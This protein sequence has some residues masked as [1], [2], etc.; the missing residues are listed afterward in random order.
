MSIL[1]DIEIEGLCDASK[2]D[3]SMITPFIDHSRRVRDDDP[4][5]SAIT[6][7]LSSYGYD[8][9]LGNEFLIFSNS[10]VN[11]VPFVDPKNFNPDICV[12]HFSDEFVII[13][14]HGFMLGK[15]VE[16][17]RMPENVTCLI[18]G[19]STYARSGITTLAT[20]LEAGWHGQVTLEFYNATP[21]PVKMYANEGCVQAQFFRGSPCRV[22][23]GT[24]SGKYQGQTGVT[25]PIV[26]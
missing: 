4:N 2:A 13:P 11:S 9:R 19:K 25:L 6:F 23:Y 10:N 17:I 21:L 7:G 26:R 5:E 1:S 12:R 3:R 24:R 22:P 8:L 14:P 18:T 15:S 16:Y 20:P